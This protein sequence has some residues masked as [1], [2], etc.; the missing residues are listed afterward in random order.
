MEKA[1][2]TVTANDGSVRVIELEK[3]ESTFVIP[4]FGRDAIA[5]G[6]AIEH[7]IAKSS[8]L[9]SPLR[10]LWT[11]VSRGNLTI[12]GDAEP[13]RLKEA[14]N[15]LSRELS[16][17]CRKA[18]LQQSTVAADPILPRSAEGS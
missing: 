7:V 1:K 5:A 15:E 4:G 14:V 12:A 6:R 9:D 13:A 11:K 18:R 10:I 17:I 3:F 8:E 2:K 16:D